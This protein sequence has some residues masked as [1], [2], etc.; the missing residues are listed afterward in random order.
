MTTAAAPIANLADKFRL[1]KMQFQLSRLSLEKIYER[2]EQ[3]TLERLRGAGF[4]DQVIDRFFKPFF[5]GVFLNSDLATSS[6]M[7]DFV[8]QMFSRG[9]AALP[10]GGIGSIPRQIAAS[11]PTGSIRTDSFV[12]RVNRNS[13]RLKSGETL[14]A[15][16]VV[17]ACEAPAAGKLLGDPAI[18]KYPAHS[19]S[20]FYFAA[21]RPPIVEPVLLLNGELQGPINSVC[22]PSQTAAGY[23]PAGKSLISVTVLG[24][25]NQEAEE[26]MTQDVIHQLKDWFGAQVDGWYPL[27]TYSISYAL[28]KQT[29]PALT[30]V[31]KPAT[32]DDGIFVCGDYLDTASLN[33]AMASG[34][35]AAESILATRQQPELAKYPA[36][37]LNTTSWQ[38]NHP[39]KNSNWRLVSSETLRDF[40]VVSV[41]E[42]TYQFAPTGEQ[43]GYVVCESA[44]WVLV[45]AITPKQDVVFVRQFRHGFGE[46]VLEIPGG[47]MDPG[48]TPWKLPF[49]NWKRKLDTFPSRSRCLVRYFPIPP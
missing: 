9:H 16:H 1:A 10:A 12:E 48:E 13:I 6:R 2:P 4:S 26:N 28:P 14:T 21:D 47:V 41:R 24:S 49:V 18:E 19:V 32:R 22:V 29:P 36:P 3:T 45:I 30:P 37:N 33:G 7:F 8:F 40:R 20:C 38:N 11:L 15:G 43:R 34:R 25:V 35:L 39:M 27:R 44:D 46:V 5:G 31:T 17:V 42:N 23:A